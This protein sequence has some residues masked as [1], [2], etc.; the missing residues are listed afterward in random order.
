M[1]ACHRSFP[2]LLLLSI[3]IAGCS[4]TPEPTEIPVMD[5]PLPTTTLTPTNTPVIP[6]VLWNKL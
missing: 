2:A 6:S 1:S 4:A 3:L 5:T